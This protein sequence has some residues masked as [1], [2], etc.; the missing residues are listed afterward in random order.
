MSRA[1]AREAGRA[2]TRARLARLAERIAAGQ[3]VAAVL[4]PAGPPSPPAAAPVVR[5]AR[6]RLDTLPEGAQFAIARDTGPDLVYEVL[7][8]GVGSVSIL[9][10]SGPMLTSE[11][12]TTIAPACMVYP[13]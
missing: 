2:E 7:R 10:R 11:R 8:V 6:V 4:P 3:P 12:D 1:A 13:L 5:G 9:H